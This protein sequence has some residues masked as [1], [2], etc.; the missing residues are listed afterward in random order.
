M[1][2][3]EQT[4]LL[5]LEGVVWNAV[6]I[7]YLLVTGSLGGLSATNLLKLASLFVLC[8][9]LSLSLSL[10]MSHTRQIKRKVIVPLRIAR[11]GCVLLTNLILLN[12]N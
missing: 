10:S 2:R 9:A 6:K 11:A 1:G 12:G 4:P 5:D 7:Y 8:R 3:T